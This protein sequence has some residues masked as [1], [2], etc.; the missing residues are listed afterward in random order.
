MSKNS[1]KDGLLKARCAGYM[2]EGY[3]WYAENNG[4]DTADIVRRALSEYFNKVI[5]PARTA[6]RTAASAYGQ[7]GSGRTH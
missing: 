1:T 4:L 7:P 2:E 6:A 3:D 5:E